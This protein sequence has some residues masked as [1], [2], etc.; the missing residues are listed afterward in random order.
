MIQ[1][2]IVTYKRLLNTTNYNTHRYI[3]K[4]FNT[5]NRLTGLIGPRGTGK[6]ILLLQYINEKIDDKN[7]CI[8]ASLDHIYFANNLLL[9]FVNELYE[10]YG[11][12]YFFFDEIHKYPNWN[13]E[14]K[15]IYDSYP[16]I[17]II[18]SG[19]SSIE[20]TKGTY[21]L[22]RRGVL[23]RLE[24]LSFRE[25]LLFKN[26]KKIEPVSFKELIGNKNR[27]ENEINKIE[28][29]RG[30][31][32]TYIQ[33]GYYPF[34]LEDENTYYQKLLRIVEKTIFEDIANYYK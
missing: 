21:D 20:L 4:N 30:Y 13:Q 33:K 5:D 31:F 15:N 17:K 10:L 19:S 7:V 23:F 3:Y 1:N 22:S 18:F 2:F 8:Y 29:I 26:I 32:K 34:V 25:Y 27:Y 9:D 14:L 11:I 24:G 16:D 6:T 28:K 12:K